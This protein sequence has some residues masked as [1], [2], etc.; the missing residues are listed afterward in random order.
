MARI[1]RN[2]DV[3]IAYEE[4]GTPG[5][6]PL[7]LIMGLT[8][9]MVWWPDE[10][11]ERLA[12]R[13][14]HVVRFDNRDT[15][16]STRFAKGD[17]YTAQDMAADAVAVLDAVGW[18]SAHIVGTSL[19]AGLAQLLSTSH[20]E[21]VRTLTAIMSGGVGG[22]LNGARVIQF[23]VLL[24]LARQRFADDRAGQIG[25]QLAV[26]RAMSSPKH[27]FEEEWARRTAE[28]SVDRGGID[29]AATQRQ[30]RAGWTTG[31]L[32]KKLNQLTIPALVVHG[33]DDPLIRVRAARQLA[34]AIPG[35]KLVVYPAMGHELPTHL[36]D[37]L[38]DEIQE[39][40]K[41]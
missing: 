29:P 13:G 20:P 39:L 4:F 35:S 26:I 41:R 12:E 23:G 38:A 15:G 11:C 31:N 32:T 6:E 9:Q 40:A 22:M 24:R 3:E 14:F 17:K 30:T 33:E 19:G 37:S 1:A 18:E 2:G 8:F 10:F 5:G 21:R 25:T 28:I 36:F 7:L 27:P 34:G 16:L